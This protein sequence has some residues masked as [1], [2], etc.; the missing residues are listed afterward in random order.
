M[1]PS[2]GHLEDS[3]KDFE[4]SA[5]EPTREV[6]RTPIEALDFSLEVESGQI[7]NFALETCTDSMEV[8]NPSLLQ[9]RALDERGIRVPIPNWLS[10][11]PRVDEYIY[12]RAADAAD[13]K[14]TRFSVTVPNGVVQLRVIGHRWHSKVNTTLVGQ[15][16]VLEAQPGVPPFRTQLGTRLEWPASAY[17]E[18]LEIPAG[19]DLLDVDVLVSGEHGEARSPFVFKFLDSSDNELPP[20][21]ELPQSPTL[22]AYRY[23]SAAAGSQVRNELRAGIPSGAERIIVEGVDW[24]SRLAT[25][26]DKPRY[27]F[28]HS[29]DEAAVI[30]A[31]LEG[32]SGKDLIVI[33]TTAPPLGHATLSLRPNNLSIEY[34]RAGRSVFFI[35]FGSLQ[36]HDAIVGDGLAQLDRSKASS[37]IEE[38]VEARR[39]E[40]N[41]YI[42][43]SFPSLECITRAEYLKREGW[44][45]VYEVRDDMEEF[46]RVGYSKWYHPLLERKLLEIADVRVTVS[47]ALTRKMQSMLP[48]RPQVATLPNGVAATTLEN[49]VE[50]RSSGQLASRNASNVIGYVGHLTP[51]WFDWGLLIA[52]A[53]RLPGYKFEI[54]GHGKPDKV[55]LPPN[56]EYLGSMSH[57]ELLPYVSNWRVGLI[58][59]ISS[60]LTR[61]VDPNKIYEYFAWGMRVVTAPMG[62]VH[63]YPSTWVYENVDQFVDCLGVAMSSPM[64]DEELE[65]IRKFADDSSWQH[66]AEAMIELIKGELS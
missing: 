45:V 62:S 33:D 66:R 29:G 31:L 23:L 20:P 8:K 42:C 52:G 51:S 50:L 47:D 7:V 27:E 21:E 24:P 3:G 49:S 57:G 18:I 56:V 19:A 61:G 11:S 43:S 55:Q 15:L 5:Q 40:S 35:P 4:Q 36:G 25:L 38:L 22:G 41:I 32:Y 26:A 65:V 64:G 34:N 30:R 17:R 39:G 2:E 59:F 12:L 10:L 1:T 48:S 46:N 44:R 28:S 16:E 58:P 60:P 6:H 53:K 14:L 13:P 9:V 37:V 63:R 54:V